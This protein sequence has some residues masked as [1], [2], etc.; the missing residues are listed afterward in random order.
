M[1]GGFDCPTV[2]GS[3]YN[4]AF[5]DHINL[6]FLL[7]AELISFIPSDQGAAE[8][9]T[10]VNKIDEEV[11]SGMQELVQCVLQSSNN[12]NNKTKQTFLSVVKSFYYLAHCPYATLN[13]HISKV[14]FDRVV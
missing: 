14:I 9:D 3:Q 4:F 7:T 2:R 11:D 6:H 5:E 12:L 10:I 13:T 1:D 8:K